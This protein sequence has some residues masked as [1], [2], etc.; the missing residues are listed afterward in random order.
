[1]ASVTSWIRK[2]CKEVLTPDN[3]QSAVTQGIQVAKRV[4][5][6]SRFDTV[7]TN[8]EKLWEV[9]IR[10]TIYYGFLPPRRICGQRH[11]TKQGEE[12]HRRV[13]LVRQ[14]AFLVEGKSI[15]A[16]DVRIRFNPR[17]GSWSYV[18]Q[19]CHTIQPQDATMNLAWVLPSGAVATQN[20]RASFCTSFGHVLGLLHEHQSPAHGGT[21]AVVNVQAAL[22]MYR[23]GQHWPDQQIYDQVINVYTDE[24]RVQLLGSRH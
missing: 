4:T 3:L 23:T 11:P 6:S 9:A 8:V 18:G 20:E 13:D 17:T 24:G 22:D 12:R 21:L 14:R 2:T 15:S 10:R 16:C 7:F 1:M 19:D 5:G